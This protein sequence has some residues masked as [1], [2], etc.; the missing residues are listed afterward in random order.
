MYCLTFY[1]SNIWISWMIDFTGTN[2]MVSYDCTFSIGAAQA[3]TNTYTVNTSLREWTIRVRLATNRNYG[4][5]LRSCNGDIIQYG[6]SWYKF[7]CYN[8]RN[9]RGTQRI[10]GLPVYSLGQE[11]SGTWS[12]TRHK[13]PI[14]QASAQGLTHVRSLHACS[15]PQSSSL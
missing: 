8:K 6:W 12:M 4:F 7:N 11:Q 13:V 10:L 3:R 1:T 9:L 2:W 15:G 5:V 14:P